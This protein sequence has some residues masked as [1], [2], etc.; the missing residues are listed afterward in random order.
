[1]ACSSALVYSRC[2][3]SKTSSVARLHQLALFHDADVVRDLAYHGKVVGNEQVGQAKVDCR[4]ASRF[5]TC[6]WTRTS[7]AETASSQMITSGSAPVHA[8]WRYAA[9][10]R[11]RVR[12][13]TAAWWTAAAPP[14]PAVR[15]PSS[16]GWPCCR[17]C[18]PQRLLDGPEDVVHRVQGTVGILEDG[19]HAAAEVEELLALQR[20]G[21]HAVE[22]DLALSGLLQAGEPSWPQW[23]CPNRTPPRSP[24]WS[25]A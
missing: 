16:R 13:G 18:G 8:R 19:L 11:R 22:D 15:G 12:W 23:T 9:A 14:G 10:G 5:S 17:S 1:M 2:G 4:S 21:I 20:R 7:R 6:A 25:R 3:A 24:S